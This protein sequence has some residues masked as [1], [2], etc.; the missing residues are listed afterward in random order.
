MRCLRCHRIVDH[1]A[2]LAQFAALV[3]EAGRASRSPADTLRAVAMIARTSRRNSAS[4]TSQAIRKQRSVPV[5]RRAM[6]RRSA[7]FRAAR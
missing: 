4:P 2:E 6:L 3:T 1:A 7:A 5:A